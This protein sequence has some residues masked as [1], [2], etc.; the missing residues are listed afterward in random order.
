MNLKNYF[1]WFENALPHK[2]CDEIIK[3][4]K[5]LESRKSLGLIGGKSK[6]IHPNSIKKEDI[7]Q[8]KKTRNSTV[9]WMDDMWIYK[10][11]HPYIHTANKNAGW[12]F[13]WS[14]SETCQFTVYKK[15]QFY[16]WHYD[17]WEEPYEQKGN[18][19]GLVRKLSVTVS[20][21]DPKNYKG[22]ELE[23][24]LPNKSPNEKP[25]IVECNEIRPRGSLVVFPSFLWHRV[26]PVIKGTRYSL[27]IWNLGHSFK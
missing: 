24:C 8:M 10:E 26:K 21:S 4:A 27:V 14:W 7:K 9:V 20:L 1:W 5:Q 17:S 3:H 13:N 2:F 23:F 12:N 22:G 11:I 19:K 18:Y 6:E 15:N 16:D 25:N